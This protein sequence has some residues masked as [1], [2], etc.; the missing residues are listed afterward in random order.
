M[1]YGIC[2][3]EL[4]LSKFVLKVSV[5]QTN[6]LWKALPGSLLRWGDPWI[7]LNLL[8]SLACEEA[9]GMWVKSQLSLFCGRI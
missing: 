6:Y 3:C 4:Q 5:N 8:L 9:D 1:F 7:P 2:Q